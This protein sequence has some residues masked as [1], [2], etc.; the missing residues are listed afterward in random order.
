MSCVLSRE[1]YEELYQER[2]G[3]AST[4]EVVR[5]LRLR[6][7]AATG[8]VLEY[9]VR[10]G[11][12]S[13]GLEGRL[14]RWTREDVDRVAAYLEAEG[15]LTPDAAARAFYGIDAAQDVRAFREAQKVDPFLTRGN[16]VVTIKPG[17]P[18]A[19]ICA[20]VAY[21]SRTSSRDEQLVSKAG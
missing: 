11:I 5:E 14:R 9:V 10:K 19:G 15:M 12:A 20:E 18:D 4:V 1:E 16:A 3:L 21:R 7:L 13:P 17:A 2:S 8:P 6:G